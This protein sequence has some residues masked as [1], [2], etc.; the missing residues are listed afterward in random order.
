MSEDKITFRQLVAALE[1]QV[2]WMRVYLDDRH[3]QSHELMSWKAIQTSLEWWG[4]RKVHSVYPGY[5]FVFVY[6]E[7][8]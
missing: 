2:S 3:E 1:D 7:E 4:N 6:L 8:Q 5:R